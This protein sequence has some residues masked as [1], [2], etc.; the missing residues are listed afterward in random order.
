MAARRSPSLAAPLL[1]LLAAAGMLLHLAAAQVDRQVKNNDEL[2]RA[3]I[4]QT[5]TS[6]GLQQVR[7][8]FSRRLGSRRHC[9]ADGS[10]ALPMHRCTTL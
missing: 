9:M 3:I 7:V 10:L 5:V 8:A 4:D 2:Y 1:L 6:I